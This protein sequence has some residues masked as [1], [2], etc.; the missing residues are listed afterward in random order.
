MEQAELAKS[1]A[2]RHTL[3]QEYDAYRRYQV[4]TIWAS[5]KVSAAEVTG[6]VASAPPTNQKRAHTSSRARTR[7]LPLTTRAARLTA[8]ILDRCSR[9]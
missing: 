6:V 9:R 2:Q 4:A 7:T 5:G 3:L 8:R 1:I